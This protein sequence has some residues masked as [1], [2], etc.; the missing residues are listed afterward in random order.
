MVRGAWYVVCG[1]YDV[2]AVW[3]VPYGVWCEVCDV[4][5]A[6]CHSCRVT[7]LNPVS[8]GSFAPRIRG[9]IQIC[10]CVWYN[11]FIRVEVE[12][13]FVCICES[14]VRVSDWL[15]MSAPCVNIYTYSYV[16]IYMY[17]YIY[18]YIYIVYGVAAASRLV[19]TARLFFK[20]ALQ[21]QVPFAQ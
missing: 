5:C 16:Y 12:A 7:L 19:Y 18:I 21:K 10:I 4:W 11:S 3:C 8:V 14:E 17:V 6:W 2:S 15:Y 13:Q 20:G 9:E 1:V